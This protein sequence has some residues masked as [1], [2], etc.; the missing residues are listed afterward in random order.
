MIRTHLIRSAVAIL[1]AALMIIAGPAH[2]VPA[3]YFA[4]FGGAYNDINKYP[5]APGAWGTHFSDTSTAAHGLTLAGDN[6]YWLEDKSVWTQRLDGSGK[7]LLQSFGVA[8][9]DLA[10]DVASGSYFTS[11][12]GAY[13]DINKYPLTPGAWG[14]HFT[15]T[16]ASAH[17][18]TLAGS[19]LYWL[20]DRDVWT[21]RLDGSGKTLLQRFG[22]APTDLAIDINGGSYFVSF[23][24]AYDDINKYPLT[25]MA[26]GTHFTDTSTD[27]RGL[28]ITGD[29]LY[30][31]EGNDVWT[32]RLDGSGKTLLQRFGIAPV[33]LAVFVPEATPVP[34][35]EGLPIFVAGLVMVGMCVARR[36]TAPPSMLYRPA[37]IA[38]E[39]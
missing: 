17:G 9:V 27:A 10:V 5:L 7:T 4:S 13:N 12:G 23:G 31:L 1:G 29:S 33:D 8:P 11:F 21:Q 32:Q 16:S 39:A 36:R 24:G 37:V 28:T 38:I 14:V 6:L 34:E 18:L 26:W 22:V 2:A 19:S 25:A 3:S 20:E 30:W 15:D 35:P